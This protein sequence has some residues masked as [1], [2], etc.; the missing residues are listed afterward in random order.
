MPLLRYQLGDA[1]RLAEGAC[2]CGLPEDGH[3]LVRVEGRGN[4]CLG[5]VT[6]AMLD[7]A[8]DAVDASLSG[9][10]LDKDVLRV[11][12]SDGVR[13]AA[14]VSALL[15]RPIAPR[16]EAAILPEGSGKFRLVKP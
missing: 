14:A 11:V 8:I 15:D 10:Q 1:V 4:D 2:A 16:R 6:P 13:A 7:D 5:A 9:W 12:G 3:Q